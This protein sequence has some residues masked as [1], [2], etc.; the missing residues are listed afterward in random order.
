[1]KLTARSSVGICAGGFGR[2]GEGECAG[3]LGLCCGF[4]KDGPGGGGLMFC[5]VKGGVCG[6]AGMGS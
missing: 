6:G 4:G 3:G 5:F 2:L 1:M